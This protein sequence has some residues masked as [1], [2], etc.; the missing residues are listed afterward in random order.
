MIN[1][2]VVPYHRRVSA[3]KRLNRLFRFNR[4]R[5]V[6]HCINWGNSQQV[7]YAALGPVMYNHPDNVRS[8]VSKLDCLGILFAG[9]IP[10]VEYT[11]RRSEAQEWLRRYKVF[12][13]TRLEGRSGQGIVVVEQ[14]GNLP[15]A[16]LYTRHFNAK[17]EFRVHVA[18]G[19]VIRIQQKKKLNGVPKHDVRS[20]DNGYRYSTNLSIDTPNVIGD[21]SIQAI[22]ALGLDF[23]AVD[24]LYMASN[25]S[26]RVLEVNTAPGIE[27]D[28]VTD[29]YNA[30][31]QEINR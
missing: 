28:T 20:Y 13:R 25:D 24:I 10:H 29:Y 23:G 22:R 19:R 26:A 9:Q 6:T 17:Y 5:T 3:A 31:M 12:A 16:R 27:G 15:E 2:Q 8:A 7:R 14:G 1:I 21:V 4:N 18:F 11:T 30:F